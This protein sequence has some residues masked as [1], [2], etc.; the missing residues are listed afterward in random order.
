MI[1]LISGKQGSGKTATADTLKE[2]LEDNNI[3][4]F[5]NKFA[6]PLYEMH[7]GVL[8]VLEKYGIKRDI[9]KDGPLLQVLG[10]D[11]GRNTVDKDIW[12][13]CIQNWYNDK[14]HPDMFS[15]GIVYLIDDM[16]FKNEFNAFEGDE[17]LKIRLECSEEVRK[18]RCSMWRENSNHQ[19]EI[20]LDDWVDLFD[21]RI[22]TNLND[23]NEVVKIITGV[24][25]ETILRKART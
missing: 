24:V 21:F 7:D 5:C 18:A 6:A 22:D 20:D 12:V 17:V 11:W 23:L 10:T 25:N 3:T 1:V 19:S 9:V 14:P 16:R 13:K 8:A 2:K 15:N 4:V